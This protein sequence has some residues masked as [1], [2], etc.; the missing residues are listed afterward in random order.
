MLPWAR[1][2]KDLQKALLAIVLLSASK[3]STGCVPP[4]VCDPAPPPSATP[5][6]PGP[7]T[8]VIQTA[9]ATPTWTPMVCDPLPPPSRTPA[10]T[11]MVCDPPPPPSPAPTVTPTGTITPTA[12][13]TFTPMICDPAPRPPDSGSLPP[14]GGES[15]VQSGARLPLAEIRWAR[16]IRPASGATDLLFGVESPWPGADYRWSVTGGQV[17]LANG[18]AGTLVRWEPPGVP[19]RYLLQVIADWEA[20][21]LTVDVLVMSV[22]ERG[23]VT[24]L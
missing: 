5:Q 24:L 21:G 7:P 15:L 1:L 3:A 23:R 17:A 13:A 11:P 22:D 12:T 14:R 6:P 10:A 20:D 2:P 9:T 8:L 16:I 19:G 4:V 18:P